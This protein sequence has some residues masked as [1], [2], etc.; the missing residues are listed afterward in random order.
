M[1]L[2]H[3]LHKLDPDS[4]SKSVTNSNRN[5]RQNLR[6]GD[7]NF[8][9][10]WPTPERTVGCPDLITGLNAAHLDVVVGDLLLLTILVLPDAD[11]VDRKGLADGLDIGNHLDK[12][13]NNTKLNK[14]IA[15]GDAVK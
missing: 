2:G 15:P 10:C 11:N 6:D 13:K 1:E 7:L 3:L 4:S 9:G 12:E 8:S 14:R 5:A